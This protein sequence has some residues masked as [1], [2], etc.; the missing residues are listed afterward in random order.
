MD[1]A[2]YA[3]LQAAIAD[4][5]NRDDLGAQIPGFIALAEARIARLLRRK[6]VRDTGFA[7]LANSDSTPL[8]SDCNELRSAVIQSGTPTMDTPLPIVPLSMIADLRAYNAGISAYPDVVAVVD[9][10]LITAPPPDQNYTL[11]ITYFQKLVPLSGGNPTNVVLTEGP[12]A[13]FYGALREAAHY[14][15]HDERVDTFDQ[16]FLQAIAELNDKRDREEMGGDLKRA[17]LPRVF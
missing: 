11:T 4:F 9:G 13:Y 16:K 12:D 3:D 8:P 15:E 1:F 7:I 14:L 6:T 10:S 17:R 5:L 2:N